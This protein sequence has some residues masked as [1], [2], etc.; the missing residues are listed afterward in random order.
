MFFYVIFKKKKI[1][2]IKTLQDFIKTYVCFRGYLK[3]LL[4]VLS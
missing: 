3:F 2:I 4:I 1:H